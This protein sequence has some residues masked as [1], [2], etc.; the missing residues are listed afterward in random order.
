M[1]MFKFCDNEMVL[2]SDVDLQTPLAL[3]T[4]GGL[5][6]GPS[7]SDL[8]QE[9]AWMSNAAAAVDAITAPWVGILR[10]HNFD[11]VRSYLVLPSQVQFLWVW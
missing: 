7:N 1:A 3:L 11:Q 2:S 9:I 5:S 4:L 10:D 6:S 8:A